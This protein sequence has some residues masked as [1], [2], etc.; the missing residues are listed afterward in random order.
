MSLLR[1]LEA[2]AIA[3][4]GCGLIS[5]CAE[6]SVRIEYM[7]L[8]GFW[9]GLGESSVLSGHIFSPSMGLRGFGVASS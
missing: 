8:G 4:M 3:A 6:D 7:R 2:C 5:P 1:H 9:G